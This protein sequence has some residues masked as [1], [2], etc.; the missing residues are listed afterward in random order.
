MTALPALTAIV[1]GTPNDATP[2]DT[3]F[4]NLA[5]HINGELINRDGSLGMSGELTLSSS[6]PSGALVAASK[7]Y[8][9][10]T[11]A[12]GVGALTVDTAR[13][14]DAAVT[15]AKLDDG[16]VTTAKLDDGAVTFA[17]MTMAAQGTKTNGSSSV[18]YFKIDTMAFVYGT[19]RNGSNV[20]LPAGYWPGFSWKIG[21]VSGG[22]TT[23]SSSGIVST[24][25]TETMFATFYVAT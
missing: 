1:N 4:D 23:I 22:A 10:T 6:T 11:V 24:S 16:A 8:V 21:A 7:S 20:T 3:N 18:S 13:L 25:V 9:D 15:T 17:K 2:V 14:V 12:A 5:T 19:I